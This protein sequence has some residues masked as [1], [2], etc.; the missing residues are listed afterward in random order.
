M[1]HFL[2]TYSWVLG[3]HSTF[4]KSIK[5]ERGGDGIWTPSTWPWSLH[6][7]CHPHPEVELTHQSTKHLMV[8]TTELRS[9]ATTF[10]GLLGAPSPMTLMLSSRA[11]WST[12][13][14]VKTWGQIP[15]CGLLLWTVCL[16]QTDITFLI[17]W[18]LPNS[19]D[20]INLWGQ[21]QYTPCIHLFTD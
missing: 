11:M 2:R 12:S 7:R 14:A 20:T 1:L 16:L 19:H 10:W 21:P 18:L 4:Q 3:L 17:T 6:S 13:P 15:Y 8:I 9:A 5:R